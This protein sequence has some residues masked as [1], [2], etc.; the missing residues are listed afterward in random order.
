MAYAC[1]LLFAD[2]YLLINCIY[3]VTHLGVSVDLKKNPDTS[4][5]S[6]IYVK[7]PGTVAESFLHCVP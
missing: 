2:F 5:L 3:C 6:L 4:P 1:V 7:T